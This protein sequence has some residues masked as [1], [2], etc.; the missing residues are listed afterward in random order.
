MI[1][2]DKVINEAFDEAIT[3]VWNDDDYFDIGYNNGLEE[4]R[5]IALALLKGQ[6][7][8]PP[9]KQYDG[10]PKNW[11]SCWYVCGNCERPIDCYDKFC[12][13]CGRMVKWE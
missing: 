12:R 3:E 1:D 8:V 5:R 6:E 4:G 9:I 11:A 2:R 13:S 7:P 10:N